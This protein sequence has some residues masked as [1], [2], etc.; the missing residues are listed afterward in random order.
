MANKEVQLRREKTGLRS[1]A[2]KKQENTPML[3]ASVKVLDPERTESY[4]ALLRKNTNDRL[5]MQS[6]RINLAKVS[7]F[8]RQI[9]PR[10]L[11]EQR[12]LVRSLSNKA[13]DQVLESAVLDWIFDTLDIF[14][15]W[16]VFSGLDLGDCTS[17]QQGHLLTLIRTFRTLTMLRLDRCARLSETVIFALS[18]SL[19]SLTDISLSGCRWMTD[20]AVVRISKCAVTLKCINLA[21]CGVVLHKI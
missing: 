4:E 12:R 10:T 6:M 16:R 8:V 3:L 17:L 1:F 20:S 18:D 19:S 13:V 5:A 14:S 2:Q 21:D 7:G 9:D 15:G 11:M